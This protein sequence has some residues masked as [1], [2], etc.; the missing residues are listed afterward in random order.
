LVGAG[1]AVVTW[2]RGE[3]AVADANENQPQPQPTKP[4]NEKEKP[5]VEIEKPFDAYLLANPLLMEVTG[6]KVIRLENGQQVVLA[7]ASTVLENDS[8]EERLRAEKVC[9][10]KALANVVS[11][12]GGV[13]VARV[14]QLKEKTVVTLENDKET[15]RSVS[16]LLQITTARVEGIARDMPVVGRWKSADGKVFYL[17]LGVV[18]DRKGEP[19]P[20]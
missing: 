5:G 16:E 7:V 20:P 6:A 8:A 19:I 14:E 9:R 11:Q 3:T 18:C 15:G 10:V 17:A 12:K 1:W 13:Q 2:S 4:A